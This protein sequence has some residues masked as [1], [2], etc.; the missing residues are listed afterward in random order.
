[1]KILNITVSP[2]S[3]KNEIIKISDTELKIKMAAPPIEGKAN[4]KL[5]AI[6]SNEFGVPKN[7]INILKGLKSR[8]KIVQIQD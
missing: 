3:S 7:K 2:R 1:M 6:L 4:K 8:K 5:I